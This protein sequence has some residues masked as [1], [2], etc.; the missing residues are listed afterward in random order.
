MLIY[1]TGPDLSFARTVHRGLVH[2][3][4]VGEVFV[5]DSARVAEDSYVVAAQWP[6]KHWY[7]G[8]PAVSLNPLLV[9]ETLRQACLVIVTGHLGVPTD[10][11]VRVDDVAVFLDCALLPCLLPAEVTMK[12]DA[13]VTP[14][15]D[16]P[17]R[18]IAARAAFVYEGE[19][20]AT[21]TGRSTM[22]PAVLSNSLRKPRDADGDDAVIDVRP[23]WPQVE[24]DHEHAVYCDHQTDHIPAMLLIDA[25]LSSVRG[26][27]TESAGVVGFEATFDGIVEWEPSAVMR[28]SFDEE[29]PRGV[30]VDVIQG[31]RRRAEIVVLAA[32][33]ASS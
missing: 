6:R 3:S 7:F 29:D 19:Q 15:A 21:A 17:I 14:S 27:L 9:A 13:N 12:I 24:V 8:E 18:S 28:L 2:K 26:K 30:S 20:F 11:R 4:A 16:G 25:A 33:E 31:G 23:E 10:A 22:A 1:P 32:S 5:T